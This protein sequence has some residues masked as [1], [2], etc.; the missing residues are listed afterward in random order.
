MVV[1]GS[2][3]SLGIW[4]GSD[5]RAVS[6]SLLISLVSLE[7][8][9]EVSLDLVIRKEKIVTSGSSLNE[10]N[11]VNNETTTGDLEVPNV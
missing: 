1:A 5:L 4:N 9:L 8:L 11:E 7:L 3:T 2:F 6:S 10:V